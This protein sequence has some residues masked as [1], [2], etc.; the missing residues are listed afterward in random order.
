[1]ALAALLDQDIKLALLAADRGT[2][3][4]RLIAAVVDGH[5]HPRPPASVTSAAVSSIVPP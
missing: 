4:H 5:C 1:V 3:L 2:V